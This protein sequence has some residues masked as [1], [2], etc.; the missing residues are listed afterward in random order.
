MSTVGPVRFADAEPSGLATMVGE[1]ISQNIA[2]EP[3]RLGLLRAGVVTIGAP[4]AGVAITLRFAPGTLDVSDGEDRAASVA[5][6]A[7][8]NRLLDLVRAPLRFGLPDLLEPRGRAVVADL[9][10]GRLAVRG[11]LRH[12]VQVS[13]LTRL[14]SVHEREP[15]RHGHR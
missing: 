9:I 4:D 7:D 1:L 5:I 14:M 10:G 15:R 12:P 6:R 13:R 3:G 11:L 8:S 2:R